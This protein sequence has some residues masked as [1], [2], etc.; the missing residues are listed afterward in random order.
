MASTVPTATEVTASPVAAAIA[1]AAVARVA[2]VAATKPAVSKP[3]ATKPSAMKPAAMKPAA[4]KPAAPKPCWCED[5][6][7]YNEY[8]ACETQEN[9]DDEEEVASAR[10]LFDG[11]SRGTCERVYVL[12]N[13]EDVTELL[14]AHAGK[15]AAKAVANLHMPCLKHLLEQ[16]YQPFFPCDMNRHSILKK[17]QAV[18]SRLDKA[19]AADMAYHLVTFC[20]VKPRASVVV[21]LEKVAHV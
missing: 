14:C 15:F 1:A 21:A 5:D 17:L 12:T 20:G 9:F 3:S 19:V 2:A 6:D 8:E 13:H 7:V 11:T 16:A 10:A 18:A 4:M